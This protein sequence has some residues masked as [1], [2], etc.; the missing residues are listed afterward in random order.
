VLR[1]GGG[2]ADLARAADLAADLTALLME[3]AAYRRH[4]RRMDDVESLFTS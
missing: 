4:L 2:E 1:R 3:T